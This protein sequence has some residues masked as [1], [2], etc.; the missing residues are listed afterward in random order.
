MATP[1]L[2]HLDSN[3]TCTSHDERREALKTVTFN[4]EESFGECTARVIG[5]FYHIFPFVK[6]GDTQDDQGADTEV[7][8]AEVGRIIGEI[9]IVL[10]PR[11]L[12][13]RMSSNCAAHVALAPSNHHM[14]LQRDEESR[15]LVVIH[16]PVF[17]WFDLKCSC[18]RQPATHRHTLRNR[19]TAQSQGLEGWFST[20]ALGCVECLALC[21]ATCQRGDAPM[22]SNPGFLNQPDFNFEGRNFGFCKT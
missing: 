5:S 11:D 22:G 16:S 3:D 14:R 13:R 12:W 21:A 8:C 17:L 20:M 15:G 4:G 10:V 18:K 2:R 7:V 19:C 6:F 9:S 1:L